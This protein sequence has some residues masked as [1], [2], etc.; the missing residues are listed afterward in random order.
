MVTCSASVDDACRSASCDRT[1]DQAKHDAQLCQP[2]F[3]SVLFACG[4]LVVVS[5]H[6]PDTGVSYYYQDGE[7]VAMERT[8]LVTTGCFAGPAAFVKPACSSAVEVPLPA[9]ATP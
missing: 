1:L 2:K 6:A 4:D 5:D 3:T 9:C 7:L 8:D